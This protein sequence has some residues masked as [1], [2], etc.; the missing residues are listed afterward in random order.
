MDKPVWDK[1]NPV[2]KSHA[3][4]T[5]QKTKAKARARAAG[6]PYPNMVD[7]IWAARNEQINVTSIENIEEAKAT[8][9]GR[10][11]TTHV[12]PSKGG[13]C[14][15]LRSEEIEQQDEGIGDTLK[16]VGKKALEKLGHGSDE[17]MRK[18]LQKKMG[19]PQTGKKPTSEEVEQIEVDSL[20]ENIE[21]I[22]EVSVG[23]KIKAY[24]HHSSSAF[25]NAD[26][27]NDDEAEQHQKR[28][29]KIHAHILKHHGTE[30]ASHAEKAADS[31]IFGTK[32]K[33]SRGSDTLSGGLRSGLS[34]S[35]T[36]TGKIPKGTQNA[37]KSI[38]SRVSGPKGNLPEEVEQIDELDKVLHSYLDKAQ[39]HVKKL[40]QDFKQGDRSMKRAIDIRKR[41]R[42]ILKAFHKIRKKQ[43]AAD[44]AAYEKA[45]AGPKKPPETAEQ[46][47]KKANPYKPYW[48]ESK[49]AI[50][51]IDQSD[52]CTVCGQTP[53]NCT[54]VQEAT[55]AAVRMQRALQRAKEDRERQARLAKPFVDSIFK[56]KEEQKPMKEQKTFKQVMEAQLHP[57][58][59]HVIPTKVDGKTKYKVHAVGKNLAH[60]IKPGEHLTDTH[61]DD[62]AE[63]GARIKQ[64]KS[65]VNEE[66][67]SWFGNKKKKTNSVALTPESGHEKLQTRGERTKAEGTDE[68][69]DYKTRF[70]SLLQQHGYGQKLTEWVDTLQENEQK[71]AIAGI[72]KNIENRF[73]STDKDTDVIKDMDV[74]DVRK[75]STLV[76][77]KHHRQTLKTFR[78]YKESLDESISS[79]QA[80]SKAADFEFK[81]ANTDDPYLEKTL[82]GKAKALRRAARLAQDVAG[83]VDVNVSTTKS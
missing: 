43:D 8:Y 23:A 49:E 33:L 28:A 47:W 81:A 29:D 16:A 70:V 80:M 42:G 39:T 52:M 13:T 11:G 74:D 44:A 6:R 72:K 12:P 64:V 50:E 21:M 59:L 62:A 77:S 41:D 37:M 34:K 68:S 58:A 71:A 63:M 30:A 57:D 75:A 19:V 45:N 7:N 83:T 22:N 67:G 3:L 24:A 10:C 53:C 9:C 20:I 48:G 79:R 56:K 69:V 2:K 27:G 60:G 54:H 61:L 5:A 25:S 35:V 51:H 15:A 4:S 66:N 73:V 76:K 46:R 17:A 26:Y 32:R 38:A 78:T 18:D 1:P 65:K 36:K 14:P 31:A 55:S 82:K 40:E